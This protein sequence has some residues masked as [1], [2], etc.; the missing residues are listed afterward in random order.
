MKTI[1]VFVSS[2]GDVRK[3]RKI[4]EKLIR[5]IGAE[6]GIVVSVT[7]SNLLINSPEIDDKVNFDESLLAHLS[8]ATKTPG[9]DFK[10]VYVAFGTLAYFVFRFVWGTP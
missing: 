5:S 4:A 3:E 9:F 10:L 6:F 1:R 2:P 8:A 7:Y